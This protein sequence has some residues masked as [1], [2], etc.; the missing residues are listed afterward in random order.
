[1][2]TTF[3]PACRTTTVTSPDGGPH[4]RPDRTAAQSGGRADLLE[5]ENAQLRQAMETRPLIDQARGMV[6]A[7]GPCPPDQAWQVLTQVSQ[8]TNTK[9]REVAAALVATTQGDPLPSPIN[10]ALDSALCQARGAGALDE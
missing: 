7:I 10:K 4:R 2:S 6:M 8:H 5:S 9:L 1:M 3:R